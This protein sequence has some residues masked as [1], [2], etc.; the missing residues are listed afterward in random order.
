[1]PNSATVRNAM[2][3]VVQRRQ[4]REDILD[5]SSEIYNLDGDECDEEADSLCPLVDLFVSESGTRIFKAFTPLSRDEFEAI[6]DKVGVKVI[7]DWSSGRGPRCKTTPKDAFFIALA[8]CHLP[9]KWDNHGVSF[10]MTAQTAQKVCFKAIMICGPILKKTYV[11]EVSIDSFLDVGIPFHS[12][13]KYAHHDTDAMV[14]E[15]NRPCGNHQ[16]SKS[17]FSGKHHLYCNKVEAS[18]YPNGEACNWTKHY[19]GAT[20]DITIFRDNIQFHRKSTK[21]SPAAQAIVDR[22][23]GSTKHPRHHAIILDKG[24]IGIEDSVR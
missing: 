21:K 16:E 10:G 2:A 1:M 9:T 7:A 4:Q 6:W 24:Y 5:R 14:T 19:P 8:V 13:F 17:Y 20:A 22:G 12:N 18:T 23:E 15:R 3:D 11:R